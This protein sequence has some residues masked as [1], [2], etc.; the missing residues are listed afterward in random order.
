MKGKKKKKKKKKQKM[1]IQ[2]IL[3]IKR[4]MKKIYHQGKVLE[5]QLKLSENQKKINPV[6]VNDIKYK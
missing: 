4:G 1:K 2:I 5:S 3:K 6:V